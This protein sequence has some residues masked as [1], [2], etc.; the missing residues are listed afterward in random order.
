MSKEPTSTQF[1]YSRATFDW[2]ETVPS[3]EDAIEAILADAST[4]PPG[5]YE[6]RLGEAVWYDGHERCVSHLDADW[7]ADCLANACADYV[8]SDSYP[9]IKREH[10]EQAAEKV[11]AIVL[12]TLKEHASPADFFDVDGEV[13]IDVQVADGQPPSWVER[14]L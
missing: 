11:Q 1:S 3:K 13:A 6:Y 8:D 9:D 12:A 2:R 10:L 4:R 5:S 7:I 14:E